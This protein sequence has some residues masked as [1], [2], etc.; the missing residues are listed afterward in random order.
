MESKQKTRA[1][2][3]KNKSRKSSGDKVSKKFLETKVGRGLMVFWGIH[4]ASVAMPSLPGLQGH[5]K[6][7]GQAALEASLVG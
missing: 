6:L 7:G 3:R 2:S 4:G 1:R 5:Q